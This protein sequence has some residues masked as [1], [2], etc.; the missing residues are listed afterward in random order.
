MNI[1][2][3]TLQYKPI[4]SVFCAILLL[5]T[6]C[7]TKNTTQEEFNADRAYLDVI[8]Q[9][10]LGPRTPGS[11]AHKNVIKWIIEELEKAGWETE[12]QT[13]RVSDHEIKNIIGKWGS[14]KPWVIIG[15]HYDSRFLADHDPIEANRNQPVPGANDGASG[16][17][18]LLELARV[19][20]DYMERIGD[21][22]RVARANTIWLVFFDAEDNGN[23]SGW[24]WILGSSAFVQ[25][26]SQRPDTAIIIDMIGDK[27]LRIFQEKNSDPSLSNEIWSAATILG[28]S[29][30][31]IPQLKHKIIDDHIPFI[32]AGIRAVDLI[33]F[34]YPYY[35]T[36]LD[37]P[38]KVSGQS[39]KIVGDTLIA[40]IMGK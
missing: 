21:L 25:S 28:Y 24:N 23:I 20:P 15:A 32:N 39:L 18:V 13:S 33:D 10:S 40:W 8:K 14:G 29:D 3:N 27:D 38:D 4:T 17:A 34:D 26:L 5:F 1:S 31:F 7:A 35:H 36:T 22:D 2:N 19:L 6:S 12:I 16:V 30:Y 11:V 37:S 9:V